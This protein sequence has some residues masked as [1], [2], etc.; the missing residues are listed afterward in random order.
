[1]ALSLALASSHAPPIFRSV[2]DWRRMH[3]W[4]VR[5]VPQPAQ[6]EAETDEVIEGYLERIR[7]A[8]SQLRKELEAYQ[9]EAVVIVG[10]DQK[11][12]FGSSCMPTFA[13]HTG[14]EVDG[15]RNIFFNDEP[16]AEN[17][18]TFPCH[19]ELAR[20]LR[21]QLI[22]RDFDIAWS[23]EFRPAGR[24]DAGMSHAHTYIAAELMRSVDA[25]IIPVW[26]NTAFPPQPSARRCYQLG[27]AI[28]AVLRGVGERVAIVASGGLSHDPK[29]PRAGW[30]DEPLDRWVLDRI[31]A[32][33]GSALRRLF[34]FD[35]AAL[36][37]GTGEIRSWITVAGAAG[38][39]R[40]T[41]LDY[42]PAYTAITG[43]GFAYWAQ[44]ELL[45][46]RGKD[47]G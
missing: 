41:V 30:I 9:P 34:T 38:S 21:D 1:M 3:P 19:Q 27:Q 29:G 33:D 23:E 16:E 40:A 12:V 15:T 36:H 8:F 42:I 14:P 28:E 20:Y 35:S 11:E 25:P 37:K 5:D 39:A 10:N 26:V 2:A 45:E 46:A 24:P 44:D 31:A 13:I 47:D 32:G 17:H 43:L 22:E 6:V 7:A 18:I 4:M